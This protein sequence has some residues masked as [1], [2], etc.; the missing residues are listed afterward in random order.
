MDDVLEGV[1]KYYTNELCLKIY[2]CLIPDDYSKP[3]IISN[4]KGE[5]VVADCLLTL[6]N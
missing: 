6:A 2:I 3:T 4:V 1:T 5:I